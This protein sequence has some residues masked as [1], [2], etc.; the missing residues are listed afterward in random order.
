M[1]RLD[2]PLLTAAQIEVRVSTVSN[3]GCS[4]LLYK[5]ARC[6]MNILDSKVGSQNWQR[7][8]YECKGNLFC[9]VGIK[10]GDEWIW[11]D[12]CGTES[13]T[14]KQK[15][16]SSDSFKRA[17][18]N[19]GIGRELYTSPFIWLSA[20]KVS[21]S[22]KNGKYT[23]YDKFYVESVSFNEQRKIVQLNICNEKTGKTVFTWR[24][25][26]ENKQGESPKQSDETQQPVIC[27]KCGK[28]AKPVRKDGVV[29][30]AEKVIEVLGMCMECHRAASKAE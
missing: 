29:T 10:N 12:D 15:G 26:G 8:H 25:R 6:D 27:P 17:C 18:F 16:E 13:Y 23:T 14:E 5:D 20:D 30:S 3:K 1:D 24:E 28:Q 4:L 11:K 7:K 2:F 19:W 22:E 9:S 21:L